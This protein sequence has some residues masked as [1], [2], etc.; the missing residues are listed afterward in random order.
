[1]ILMELAVALLLGA[2]IGIERGWSARERESGERVAGVRTHALIG[3]FGGVAALLS[4]VL[5]P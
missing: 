2:L 1:M 4:E 3:L 5:T